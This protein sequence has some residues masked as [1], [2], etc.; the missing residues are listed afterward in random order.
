[1]LSKD[2]TN[3]F[4][5]VVD[6]FAVSSDGGYRTNLL[7]SWFLMIYGTV[8]CW[9]I[10][11]FPFNSLGAVTISDCQISMLL[12][13]SC[14]CFAKAKYGKNG[15]E[16]NHDWNFTKSTFLRMKLHTNYDYQSRQQDQTLSVFSQAVG[17]YH[18]TAHSEAW[19]KWSSFPH[20]FCW[21]K[22][23]AFWTKF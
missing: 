18:N 14:R 22:P 10:N 2:L 4:W 15:M 21:M 11:M 1:M 23:G 17:C 5:Y 6:A 12:N 16:R 7:H 3:R 20:I 13:W 19:T 9:L 8:L